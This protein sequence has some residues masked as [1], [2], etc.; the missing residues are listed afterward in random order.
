MATIPYLASSASYSFTI[1]QSPD[2]NL[3]SPVPCY[4]CPPDA[5][6]CLHLLSSSSSS[7]KHPPRCTSLP[8]ARLFMSLAGITP[9]RPALPRAT[10]TP[11][12]CQTTT[13][14][15]FTF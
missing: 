4:S 7:P 1:H 11:H 3:S 14:T 10:P 13:S 2:P 12:I 5:S 6:Y 9:R 8:L 15:I